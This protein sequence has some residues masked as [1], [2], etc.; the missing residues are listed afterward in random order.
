M[1]LD[2]DAC[3]ARLRDCSALSEGEV[4]SLCDL[5]REVLSHE[6]NVQVQ[7]IPK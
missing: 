3:I 6:S 1:S 4:R 2:L 7:I 5:A